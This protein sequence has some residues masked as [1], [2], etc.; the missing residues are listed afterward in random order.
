MGDPTC[1]DCLT[2]LLPGLLAGE[3]PRSGGVG[4]PEDRSGGEGRPGGRSGDP[5]RPEATR[6]LG[7]PHMEEGV[8]PPRWYFRCF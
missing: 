2:G 8:M 4:R 3:Q 1:L 5:G 6:Y 7:R